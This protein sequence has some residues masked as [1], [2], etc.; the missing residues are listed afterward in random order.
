MHMNSYAWLAK[1]TSNYFKKNKIN[2]KIL[3]LGSIYGVVG[4]NL[5]I[6]ENTS[7]EENMSH[8]LIKGGI[9]NLTRQMASYYGKY[10]INI[11]TLCPGGIKGHV[12]NSSSKQESKFIKNYN[13]QV[14]LKRLGLASE[15]AEV[16]VFLVSPSSS[17]ITGAT[18]MVDGGWTAI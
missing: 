8:S 7:M 1:I 12:A 14:P 15:V 17:Y 6:Y 9:I 11:N 2:G 18:I 13:K 10:N 4:Q 3:Q 5:N 16:A